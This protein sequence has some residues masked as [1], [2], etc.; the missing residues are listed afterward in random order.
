MRI[1]FLLHF[2]A[3]VPA[4]AGSEDAPAYP[5]G[6]P[7]VG[8][9]TRFAR[10]DHSHPF[11]HAADTPGFQVEVLRK[12]QESGGNVQGFSEL[13]SM[14]LAGSI[15]TLTPA[16]GS[17]LVQAGEIVLEDAPQSI[18]LIRPAG[19]LQ[20]WVA[21]D[22]SA[23]LVH[24]E[25]IEDAPASWI[26]VASIKWDIYTDAPEG[27]QARAHVLNLDSRTI[28]I[29]REWAQAEFLRTAELSKDLTGFTGQARLA[30]RLVYNSAARSITLEV[31]D[32][33]AAVV[34]WRGRRIQLHTQTIVLP[35]EHV[36]EY[37]RIHPETG[38]FLRAGFTPGFDQILVAY[39]V[40]SPSS[41]FI[42]QGDERHGAERDTNW[43]RSQHLDWGLDWR[44]G[45]SL[46]FELQEPNGWIEVGSPIRIADEDLEFA[47]NHALTP[48]LPFQQ[49][50]ENSTR[51]PV[52]VQLGEA[53]S[54][55]QLPASAEG[56]LGNPELQY[57][58]QE[59]QGWTLVPVPDGFFVNY[60][61]V[62]TTS[63]EE[64]VKLVA[65]R[66]VFATKEAAEAELFTD[67][68]LPLAELHL[69]YQFTLVRDAG[70]GAGREAR[71]VAVQRISKGILQRGSAFS[72]GAHGALV[73]RSDPD[74]HPASAIGT[75]ALVG[76]GLSGS[77]VQAVLELLKPM[78]TLAKAT[79]AQA[80]EGT[81]DAV[82]MTPLRVKQHLEA[83]TSALGR[84]LVSRSTA[85]EM[86]DDLGLGTAAT[87]DVGIGIGNVMEVGAF[88]L[89][90]P[91]LVGLVYGGDKSGFGY[92]NPN[93]ALGV[94]GPFLNV[95]AVRGFIISARGFRV[96]V[97]TTGQDG[98]PVMELIHT[99]NVLSTTG[100]STEYPMSQ[101]AVTDALNTGVLKPGVTWENL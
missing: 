15:F 16:S 88:G 14:D 96:A 94:A 81:S 77:Q 4:G 100:Q 10:A 53:G 62:L 34:Y 66:Q 55:E 19:A 101:K 44:S 13:P 64:P 12:L 37:A 29:L 28:C 61:L 57:N 93:P 40:Y 65:G 92:A 51:L 36:N 35:E 18:E 90:G 17:F 6:V 78:A 41:G 68:A 80:E 20:S 1:P 79:Q 50:L 95:H 99:R 46:M 87:R 5:T 31:L 21:L 33:E 84:T 49:S 63:Q 91:A 58:T 23:G 60:F 85:S 8:T 48:A 9:S 2:G 56:W 24:V 47:I 86:R 89:G 27:Y 59:P 74:S 30:T 71:I 22:A 67:Y 97:Q 70:I 25:S 11:Q 42:V 73:G 76:L 98:N 32:P 7:T 26:P 3:E 45:G 43:H 69:L 72:A 52:L 83:R 38:Q 75:D 39:Y 54:L 82:G